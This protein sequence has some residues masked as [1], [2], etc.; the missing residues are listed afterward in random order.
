MIAVA[1]AAVSNPVMIAAATV[2]AIAAV[3]TT[4]ALAENPVGTASRARKSSSARTNPI[5]AFSRR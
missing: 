4:N 3:G 2:V 1:I 5:I